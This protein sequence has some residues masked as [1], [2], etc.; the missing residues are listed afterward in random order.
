MAKIACVAT[1]KRVV[2]QLRKFQKKNHIQ[3]AEFFTTK[4]IF[5]QL[6]VS[7]TCLSVATHVSFTTRWRCNI[8][9]KSHRL[10]KQKIAC[11]DHQYG[12]KTY[13]V[14]LPSRYQHP[15]APCENMPEY[16]T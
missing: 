3:C 13:P 10:Y 16:F 14:I 5:L 1:H 15:T 9:E 8:L 11:V 4:Y 6:V 12:D 7:F 2:Q